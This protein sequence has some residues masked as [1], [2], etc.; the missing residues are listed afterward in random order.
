M[1]F[2]LRTDPMKTNCTTCGAQAGEACKTT[3]GNRTSIHKSRKQSALIIA[4]HDPAR[5]KMP[6][7]MV[8]YIDVGILLRDFDEIMQKVEDEAEDTAELDRATA[9]KFGI[10]LLLD[11]WG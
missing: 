5:A 3:G 6:S 7:K 10:H 8:N 9:V 1:G 11:K 2:N 4:A